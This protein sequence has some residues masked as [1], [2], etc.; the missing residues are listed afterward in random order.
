MTIRIIVNGA[1]GRMGQETVKAIQQEKE[2]ELVAQ[3]NRNDNLSEVI[4]K[5]NP[6]I[7][8][9]FTNA[10]VAFESALTII[11]AGVHPVIGTSGLTAQQITE[12][13]KISAD[14]K[15]GGVIAPNFSI[16]AILMMRFAREAAKYLPNVEIIELHHDGKL[17]SPSGTAMK[18]ADMIAEVRQKKSE[19]KNTHETIPGARGASHHEIPI[20]SVRLPGFIASQQ[21]IFGNQ[22]ETLTI[23]ENTISRESYMPGVRLACKKVLE[24]DSLVYGLEH[25]L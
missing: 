22:G 14:K 15:L 1:N 8:I 10:A 7:V 5:I 2:F 20:H 19:N 13:Q 16:G 9:D 23:S 4:K 25:V 24:L 3:T 11:N 6:Q 21:V 17:D 12:L 18:T